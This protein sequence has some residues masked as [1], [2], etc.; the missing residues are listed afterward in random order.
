MLENFF[1]SMWFVPVKIALI[2]IVAGIVRFIAVRMID[3]AVRMM[4]TRQ[5]HERRPVVPR[6]VTDNRAARLV[7]RA[8]SM[9]KRREQRIGALGSLGRSTVTIILL[10]IVVLMILQELHFNIA[11]LLA[12][13]SIVGIAVAFG[14]QTILRDIISGI[15]ILFED[16]LGM[17]DYVQVGDIDGVVEE[18]GLRVTQLRDDSG[19]I[20]YFRNGDI[21]KV[22]NYSQGSGNGRPTPITPAT[23]SETPEGR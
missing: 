23:P 12:G 4:V 20:W 1:E 2:L 22:A 13:T 10:V 16:Q 15:F 9:D 5:S 6:K 17:G 19:T 8:T 11:A 14:V 18:I 7:A 21:A 3:K